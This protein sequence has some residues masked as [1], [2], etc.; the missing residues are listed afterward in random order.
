MEIMEE[1]ITEEWLKTEGFEQYKIEIG[2]CAW[3]KDFGD[4]NVN[5]ITT[6]LGDTLLEV[7][8]EDMTFQYL[9]RK[10]K[11]LT[12]RELNETIDCF[13]KGDVEIKYDNNH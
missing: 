4:Y 13:I 6:Q 2:R 11:Q 7:S 8:D 5:I 1:F 3:K 10:P 9:K 12:I